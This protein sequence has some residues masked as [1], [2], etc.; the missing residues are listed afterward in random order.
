MYDPGQVYQPSDDT[1]LLARA[2]EAEVR[3]DDR[4]IEIGTGSGY[5]SAAVRDRAAFL[6]ATEINPHAAGAASERGIAVVRTD[7]IQGIR[8][9]FDLILF[10]PPY[11]PTR[12]EER[13]DDWLEYALDGG[14]EGRT[15]IERFSREIP[16]ILA[17]GGR[18]LLL[19]SSLTGPAIVGE[20]FRK[21]GMRTEPVLS[22]RLE[23][24][25]ELIVLRVTRV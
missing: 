25:E 6:V 18:I 24:G 13:I 3:P 4:V 20:I 19:V 15:V 14:P 9:R 11:L 17:P 23:D 10:N 16:D 2:A 1:F 21:A 7:L 8:G 5:V 22:R 12:P